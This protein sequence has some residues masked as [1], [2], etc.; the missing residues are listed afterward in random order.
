MPPR[1]RTAPAR[2][3]RRRPSGWDR[4]RARP[5]AAPSPGS[6]PAPAQAPARSGRTR[7][8]LLRSGNRVF[9][10]RAGEAVAALGLPV[11]LL[12]ERVRHFLGH[13]GLV[14][15]GEHAVGLEG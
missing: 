6:A 15:L 4:S 2:P 9:A 10:P 5:T 12:L 14:V 8:S 3:S 7:R 1:T 13:V 11:A